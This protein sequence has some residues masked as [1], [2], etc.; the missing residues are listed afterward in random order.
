VENDPEKTRGFGSGGKKIILFLP[1]LFVLA[2][3]LVVIVVVVLVLVQVSS[4]S[5]SVEHIFS[6]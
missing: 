2:V 6:L 1:Q 3:C 5:A 4:N